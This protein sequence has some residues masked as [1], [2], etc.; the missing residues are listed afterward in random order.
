MINENQ[1]L[2]CNE[3]KT[4]ET[5]LKKKLNDLVSKDSIE[6]YIIE[7]RNSLNKN[8]EEAQLN[9]LLEELITKKRELNNKIVQIKKSEIEYTFHPNNES[10]KSEMNLIGEINEA[11]PVK[12]EHITSNSSTQ[13]N[14]IVYYR[15]VKVFQE[16]NLS[17]YI[18][19]IH[20]NQI[21]IFAPLPA[22]DI[23]ESP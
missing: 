9:S 4:I 14:F 3:T 16:S 12:H 2:L 13:S 17:L 10:L 1:R 7:K 20:L 23:E 22:S 5:N 15:Q 18:S 8:L 11:K 6:K 21:G 19:F